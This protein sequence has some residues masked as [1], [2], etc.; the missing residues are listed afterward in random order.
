M[1]RRNRN[2][3]HRDRH[4]IIPRSRGGDYRPENI[5][6]V[7]ELDH[8]AYHFIFD[9]RTPPEIIERLVERFWNGNWEYVRE[10]YERN[11]TLYH[12]RQKGDREV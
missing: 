4:H 6:R 11:A 8:Q 3:R 2:Y 5:V 10:A 7:R 9:N 12:G 1:V